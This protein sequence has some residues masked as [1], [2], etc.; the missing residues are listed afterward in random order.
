M[1]MVGD[2]EV[3]LVDN[4]KEA[5]LLENTLIKRHKP[6]FNVMLRDDKAFICLRLD[7]RHPYPR[8]EVVRRIKQD[9][10]R[11]FGPYSSATAI[12]ETL[13]LVNRYFQLRTCTDTVLE[14]RTRPCLLYQIKRCPAPCV[15]DV[16]QEE[17]R[18]NV[19]EVVLFLEG[20][21]PELVE[22]LRAAHEEAAERTP[23]RGRGALL[24]DQIQAIE[25]SL[26]KQRTVFSDDSTRTS[27]ASTAR[28]RIWPGN[29]L[30][31]QRAAGT[32]A[33]LPLHRQEFPTEEL[34]PPSS[35]STTR[36]AR[37]IPD[38][39]LLPM[40]IE[41]LGEARGPLRAAR[42]KGAGARAGARREERLVEMANKNA[43]QGFVERKKKD[44]PTR[45]SSSGCSSGWSSPAAAPDRVLRYLQF[46]GYSGRGQ[47]GGGA[48]R[49]ARQGRLPA[50]QDQELPGA[51]R[52]RGR[53]TR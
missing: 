49:R 23:L 32:A 36:A 46:P 7:E 21:E 35:T 44:E 33:Q 3:I 1:S 9:G 22:Q 47:P 53:S 42:A 5:L 13:R 45:R 11:Y 28:G 41:D 10:A 27:S 2:L 15:Y 30:R 18:R 20:K 8:L 40:E 6:R 38:E 51:G 31:P 16:P 4:E 14:K 52:L 25:R 34:S 29:P 43:E 17:Y 48:G 12:R 26:E 37:A 39:V 19:R 24:R 50:L